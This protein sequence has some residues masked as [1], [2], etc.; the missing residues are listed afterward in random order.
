M[1]Q[2]PKLQLTS[3]HNVVAAL[4]ASLISDIDEAVT[5][6]DDLD[7]EQPSWQPIRGWDDECQPIRGQGR[8]GAM[9]AVS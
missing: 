7:R 1:T 9:E 8:S 5:P 6:A 2:H 4:E 3:K